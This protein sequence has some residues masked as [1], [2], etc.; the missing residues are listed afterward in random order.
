[1]PNHRLL[2][3]LTLIFTITALPPGQASSA[4]QRYGPLPAL[5]AIRSEAPQL[6]DFPSACGIG[7]TRLQ[8][9][10]AGSRRIFLPLVANSAVPGPGRRALTA[11]PP[12][13]A[14]AGVAPE[15]DAQATLNQEGSA[16]RDFATAVEFLYTGAN[17][18]QTGV[19]LDVID[20]SRVAVVRGRVTSRDGVPLAGVKVAV[21]DRP[22]LGQTLTRTDG[23]FDLAVNG[24]QQVIIC[25]DQAG[26]LPVQRAITP[27]LRDYRRLDDVALLPIDPLVT[28]V[29]LNAPQAMQAVRGSTVRDD[30]GERQATLF[31]PQGTS[32][33][34]VFPDGRVQNISTLNVRASEYTVGENGPATMPG[35]LPPASGYTYAVEFSVDEALTAGAIDVRFSQPVI[36]YLENFLDFP[37]G[38]TVPAG[39]YNRTTGLWET[40]PN[41]RVVQVLSIADGFAV[42]DVD[43]SGQPASATALAE[44]GISDA[45]RAQ[46]A[47]LY[48]PGQSL[49]RTPVTHFTPWDCN[50]PYGPPPDGRRRNGPPPDPNQ[51]EENDCEEEGRSSI[52][53]HSQALGERVDIVGTPFSLHYRSDRMVGNIA[54]QTLR[55][56]V[57][58]AGELP[59]SLQEIRLEIEV[60]GSLTSRSF[61]PEPNQVFE[62]TWDGIDA[63]GRPVRGL[64]PASVRIGYVY[65]AV[66]YE[67]G[68]FTSAFGSF[69]SAPLSNNPARQEIIS[70][71]E[72]TGYIS[73][74]PID[75]RENGLGGWTLSEHHSYEPV[76]MRL[77]LGDGSSR[78]LSQRDDGGYT[79]YAG[80]GEVRQFMQSGNGGPATEAPLAAQAAAVGPDGNLYLAEEFSGPGFNEAISQIRRIDPD[81]IIRPFAGVEQV[82]CDSNR[83]PCGDG[84]PA[85]DAILG[86]VSDI[87]FGPDGSLYVAETIRIVFE[88]GG[89]TLGGR[90]RR[91]GTDGIITT[92]AGNAQPIESIIIVEGDGGPAT[93]APL[94]QIMSLAVGPDGSIYFTETQR[95]R[96]R[97][98]SSDGILST[99]AGNGVPCRS[100]FCGDGEPATEAEVSGGPIAISSDGLLYIGDGLRTVRVVQTDGTIETTFRAGVG[101]SPNTDNLRALPNGSILIS[102]NTATRRVWS[103]SPQGFIEP[104]TGVFP[105]SILDAIPAPQ[106]GLFIIFRNEVLKPGGLRALSFG[107]EEIFIPSIDGSEVYV[108]NGEGRHLRTVNGLTGASLYSFAYDNA[109]RLSSVT[110]GDGNVTNIERDGN[111]NPTAIVGPYGARTSISVDANGYLS[112][113]SDPAGAT[114]RATYDGASGLLTSFSNPL[115]QQSQMG[116]DSVG[117]LTSSTDA[118]GQTWTLTRNDLFAGGGVNIDRAGRSSTY[119]SEHPNEGTRSLIN[120]FP[121]GTEARIT[122]ESSGT[123]TTTYR[124]GSS[125][126]SQEGGDPRWGTLA[127]LAADL[128]LSSPSGVSM[129]R[130][131]SREAALA[132]PGDP[133]S[134]IAIT[135]TL[136]IDG[137]SATS[138]YDAASRTWQTT[139]PAGRSASQTY[140]EQGRLLR[141][142]LPGLAPENRSFDERGRLSRISF[143]SGNERSTTMGYNA[144]GELASVTDALGRTWTLSYDQVGRITSLTSPDNQVTQYSFDAVGNMTALT[145][146]GRPAHSFSYSPV[147]LLESITLPDIGNGPATTTFSY[148]N[149][150]QRT[151]VTRPDGSQISYGYSDGG[152][153]ISVTTANGTTSYSYSAGNLTTATAP[154]AVLSYTYD[155]NL[156]TQ[157]SWSGDVS[158]SVQYRYGNGMR[159]SQVRVNNANPVSLQYDGDGLLTR[160]GDLEITYA[161]NSL[162]VQNTSLNQ[163]GTTRSYDQYGTL[164]EQSTANGNNTLFRAVYTRDAVG[165]ISSL[166][167]TTG[168]QTSTYAYTY[169]AIGRLTSVQRNGAPLA[170]YSYD[171]HG[172]RLSATDSNGTN[173]ASYDDQDQLLTYGASSFSYNAAGDLLSRTTGSQTTSYDYD[174]L[175]NLLGVTLPDGR[176]IDYLIDGENRRIGKRIDGVLQQGWLYQEGLLPIAELD[177]SNNIVS[178]FI[179]GVDGGTPSYMIRD[180]VTYRII[181]D[182]LGSPRLV[183]NA[184]TGDIAQRLDYDPFGQVLTD[185]NPGFQ[186]FGFAGGIYDPDTGLLR[187]GS[188]DYDPSIGRWTT[189]DPALFDGGDSNGYVYVNNDPVNFSDPSG[190]VLPLL[191]AAALLWTAV[192]AGLTASDVLDFVEALFDPCVSDGELAAL[193]IGVLLGILGPG[194]GY[195]KARKWLGEV[196]DL[197]KLGDRTGDAAKRTS[198]LDEALRNSI[199]DVGGDPNMRPRVARPPGGGRTKANVSHEVG[200]M[201]DRW[202]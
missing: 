147:N 139:S 38:M 10:A 41:G 181:S 40:E 98:V 161:P 142:Q 31:F 84:G 138:T 90:I 149:N 194:G 39:S 196:S 162:F 200:N 133:F 80:N 75:P 132:D 11:G 94:W 146:P 145:P 76:G 151:G 199:E 124:F 8:P 169:D 86:R 174:P 153:L 23:S 52:Y 99:V 148:N 171:P 61:T 110:D 130:T 46:L 42:L 81:G 3:L 135:D 7:V 122:T 106:D 134:L 79:V 68:E 164:A 127:P 24:G 179:Y 35:E 45:E 18:V 117:R 123:V 108:F 77:M 118:A 102:D 100:T 156:T 168:G 33:E 70:W 159:L 104:L 180:G 105:G 63:Y 111:G 120:S 44:L 172:N 95:N 83:F 166:S 175:G 114:Y 177:G 12:T 47:A 85:A 160:A 17:P 101:S 163:L 6:A 167:E 57:S 109:G 144:A 62:F 155:G 67:P 188:R 89:S 182:Q 115:N 136:R 37:V 48:Q 27:P 154:D 53:C 50:W 113:I 56:P 150:R 170:S 129:Q 30:D 88:S 91:I 178:R 119:R 25:F 197:A 190:E 141:S 165:R 152:Q 173:N 189:R 187:F 195:N 28:L 96:V 21:F 2:L 78:N 107:A 51:P 13:A 26:Y 22:E 73:G 116:Y 157:A 176:A 71:Q 192:E 125:N 19:Q 14:Q 34:L 198:K 112:N 5:R 185:T 74:E 193:G 60:A 43:G 66:Y 87:A 128:T 183:V 58:E 15:P 36:N 4:A 140:D 59:E 64:Q 202:Q 32:V 69:G 9:A 29:D 54:Q 82:S 131:Q 93:D 137:R 126:S 143:G 16:P 72:W 20:R 186:P 184:A 92:V 201:G 121:D 55:I 65:P 158:G 191:G 103:M 49:W 97:R 1:M